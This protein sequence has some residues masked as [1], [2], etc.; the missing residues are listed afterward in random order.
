VENETHREIQIRVNGSRPRDLLTLIHDTFED[1]HDSFERLD[2]ETLIP[3]HCT[4]CK[5]KAKPFTFP[6]DRLYTCLDKK[7]YTIECHESGEDV[8]VRGLIDDVIWSRDPIADP[9]DHDSPIEYR[10]KRYRPRDRKRHSVRSEPETAIVIENHIHNANQQEQTMTEPSK[11][12]NFNAP[13]SGVI[14][15]DNAQVSHNSFNQVN[16][17]DTAELLQLIA[18]LRHSAATLPPDTQDAILIDL[19]DVETEVQKPAAERNPKKLKQRL[20]AMLAAAGV[21]ASGVAGATDFANTAIDL[22]SKLGIELQ[23][24]SAP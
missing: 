3:C 22:G 12:N 10:E 24:P 6:L 11:I 8:Q 1:I 2:Y 9:F 23:L 7:R 5:P 17:A 15:S 20:T 4:V 13:M 18:N 21:A 19:E 16:N 14:G